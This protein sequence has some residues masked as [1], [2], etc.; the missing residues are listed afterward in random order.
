[1]CL[2]WDPD[3]RFLRHFENRS[4]PFRATQLDQKVSRSDRIQC[5]C[6]QFDSAD[7]HGTGF[8]CVLFGFGFISA[9]FFTSTLVS[10]FRWSV[11]APTRR[12]SAPI[13]SIRTLGRPQLEE[14]HE[15]SN[16]SCL[17]WA[18]YSFVSSRV[19]TVKFWPVVARF[20]LESTRFRLRWYVLNTML[21][22]LWLIQVIIALV[23]LC[24][25][26]C[27]EMLPLRSFLHPLMALLWNFVVDSVLVDQSQR[28]CVVP[29]R[30]EG[31]HACLY[32]VPNQVCASLFHF[33]FET[34]D[35]TWNCI[36][37]C[38]IV[39]VDY[40]RDSCEWFVLDES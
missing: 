18:T 3:G 5:P 29:Y 2:W 36:I 27:L 37:S 40:C 33:D 22:F 10:H 4:N 28:I 6:A 38:F 1:M 13:V 19:Q 21:S 35:V 24:L 25:A 11:T 17:R 14:A 15:V 16:S 7:W 8:V 34:F 12:Q 32:F 26:E 20:S 39:S 23:P 31:Y 30:L 9:H